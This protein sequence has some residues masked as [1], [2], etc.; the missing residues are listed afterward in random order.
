M[1]LKVEDLRQKMFEEKVKKIKNLT[2]I[3]QPKFSQKPQFSPRI[4]N[5][6]CKMS[7]QWYGIKWLVW[8]IHGTEYKKMFPILDC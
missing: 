7:I 3:L 8:L 6:R 4:S 2:P 5:N 1:N